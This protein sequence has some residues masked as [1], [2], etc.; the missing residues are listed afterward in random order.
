MIVFIYTFNFSSEVTYLM[1]SKIHGVLLL[2]YFIS[3][4]LAKIQ[5]SL[6][7]R[8]CKNTYCGCLTCIVSQLA[9]VDQDIRHTQS[10]NADTWCQYS[11]YLLSG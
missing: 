4:F 10:M 1:T 2:L 6:T 11:S 5:N 9:Y 3:I 7:N 8:V